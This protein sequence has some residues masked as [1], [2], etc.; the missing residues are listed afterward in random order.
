MEVLLTDAGQIGKAVDVVR[1]Y[2]E[3][4]AEITSSVEEAV[5]WFRTARREEDLARLL[6]A[7]VKG[8]LGVAQ[9]REVATD[10]EEAFMIAARTANEEEPEVEVVEEPRSEQVS[11]GPRPAGGR[12]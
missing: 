4:G 6:A 12:A 1:T 8:G 11:K 3:P 2:V 9:F 10:L 5:V 7:L